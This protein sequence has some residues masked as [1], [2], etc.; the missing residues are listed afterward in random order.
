MSGGNFVLP[1]SS[2]RSRR[3]KTADNVWHRIANCIIERCGTASNLRILQ[4]SEADC[5]LCSEPGGVLFRCS[6]HSC[7]KEYHPICALVR[8]IIKLVPEGFTMECEAHRKHILY[9]KCRQQY[10]DSREYIRCD[11][12]FEW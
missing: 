12:C 9:C 2:S 1:V 11:N 8:G 4:P 6:D 3:I 10:D 7:S 5:H